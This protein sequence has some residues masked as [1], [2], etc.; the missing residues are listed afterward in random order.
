MYGTNLSGGIS[1][2][3]FLAIELGD[4]VKFVL[5]IGTGMLPRNVLGGLPLGPRGA[6]CH[7][8]QNFL[9]FLPFSNVP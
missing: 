2:F 4:L 8:K 5:F 6:L 7:R 3:S 9:G 1:F